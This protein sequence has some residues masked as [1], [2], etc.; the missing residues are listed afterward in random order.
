LASLPLPECLSALQTPWSPSAPLSS[1]R[2]PSTVPEDARSD[3]S[4]DHARRTF[5]DG[6]VDVVN[7]RCD[8]NKRSAVTLSI[9][10][11]IAR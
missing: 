5:A 6:V 7:G 2:Q 8:P 4:P 1:Q 10:Q 3:R 11:D 9:R